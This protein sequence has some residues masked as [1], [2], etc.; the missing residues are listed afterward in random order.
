[1]LDANQAWSAE[2]A[3]ARI[4]ALREFGPRWIEEPIAADHG[5]AD[6]AALAAAVDVPLAAGENLRGVAAF[7]E[8]LASRALGF[9]QPDLGKWGGFSGCRVVARRAEAAGAC[10]CPHWLGGPVGLVA[11]MH[12][13]AAVG[14]S[15][16]VEWDANPNPILDRVADQLPQVDDGHVRLADVA[17]LGLV[18]DLSLIVDLVTWHSAVR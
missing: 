9:V 17:G 16:W 12:L 3:P 11:S 2:L 5:A 7:D 10:Y 15:G 14:D 1:M 18:P 13:R 4:A 6:W 8:L